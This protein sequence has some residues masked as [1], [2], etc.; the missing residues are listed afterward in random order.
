MSKADSDAVA[1]LRVEYTWNAHRID[2][3]PSM[4]YAHYQYQLGYTYNGMIM[5]HH[6]GPDRRIFSLG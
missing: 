2:E 1:D 4:W 5:G 3:T 6:M